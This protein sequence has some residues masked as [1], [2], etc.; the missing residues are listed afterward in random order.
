LSR[1]CAVGQRGLYEGIMVDY[2]TTSP[3]ARPVHAQ[4]GNVSKE[5]KGEILLRQSQGP[6]S[7][8]E[9]GITPDRRH[10]MT[11]KVGQSIHEDKKP[12]MKE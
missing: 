10:N 11:I 7:W 3:P 2:S 1:I 6:F 12:Y 5:G 9:A 8:A 4:Q